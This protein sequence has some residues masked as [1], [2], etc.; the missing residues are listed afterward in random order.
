MRKRRWAAA[1]LVVLMLA[2]ASTRTA[3]AAP[4]EDNAPIANPDL[5]PGCG[6]DIHVILDE[7]TSIQQ[8]GATDD[9][10]RAFRAFTSALRNTGSRMAVSEF[11]T[12][13]R[14]PLSGAA[15]GAYT[16]VTDATIA[17]T[18]DPY[19]TIGF[20]PNGST[21]WEDAFRIG[22]YF[23]PRPSEVTPHLVVFITDG[24]PNKIVRSDQVTYD[25]GNPN[26]A[27]NEYELKVPLAEN[28]TVGA[29]ENPAKDRAV[30]N[31]NA[32]KAQGSHILTVAVGRALSSPA[33]L[34]RIIA[35]SGPDVFAG[36][37]AF[38][39]TTDDVYRVADFS[40]LEDA[41]RDAAFRLCAPS[42]NV[43]KLIDAN[44]DPT[45]DDL[46]PGQG[47]SMTANVAPAPA[48]WV[49]PQGATGATATGTTG[50]DGFVNF[51]WTTAAP[52]SSTIAVTEEVQPGFTNDQSATTCTY[53]TPDSPQ[54]RPLPG[55]SATAGGFSGIVPEDAIVTC[56]MV[57]RIPAAPAIEIEKSTNGDDADAAPGPFV[58]IGTTVTWTYRVTNT[59]NVPLSDI[60]VTDDRGV[61]VDCPGTSLD[62]A[63]VMTCRATGTAQPGQYENTGA[64][65][66]VGASQ[67]VGDSDPSHYFGVAPG[68][69]I[70]K[71]TNGDD[72]DEAPGPFIPVGGG[73]T[74]TY[75]VTNSGNAALTGVTVTDDQGVTVSCPQP[76]LAASASMTCTAP[77]ATAVAGQYENTGSVTGTA[78]DG[79]LVQDSDASHY[80]GAA[81][82]VVI[83]KSTNQFP[84]DTP[85]GPQ[86][87]VGG[88]VTWQYRVTNNGNVPLVDW[89]PTD[90]RGEAVACPRLV[91]LFPGRSV[92]CIA[93]GTAQA[94]QYTNIA[95]VTAHSAVD[96]SAPPV[97]A[98]DPSHYFGVQGAIDLEKATN[99]LDADAPPGPFVAIGGLVTRTYQ[100]TN[101]GNSTQTDVA[102]T[103]LRGVALSCPQTT[104]AVGES[105][106]CTGTGVAQAGQYTNFA[107]AEARTPLN[108]PV[109][110]GDPSN[111]FGAQP[112]IHL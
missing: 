74:W 44:P 101:T 4:G 87:A 36:D 104:L 29:N 56:Q 19:I 35:V 91:L 89:Q 15:N 31:A 46:Q 8:A 105:M 9:V 83:E 60:A 2:G 73:V 71:F 24:D 67:Q 5:P 58:P 13:A 94:G 64:V 62:V 90:S 107:I 26:V 10:R 82:S 103:D 41:L 30:P 34:A 80:F 22:R 32:V 47:W 42:V 66:A 75:E 98:T 27:Q 11:S 99:G 97:T 68:I 86:I 72:A 110:D 12:V 111:F 6:I 106:I 16:T 78:A 53:R 25:P 69:D 40:H 81:P 57:N 7:S 49:L 70:E 77:V 48:A 3:V 108:E 85:P 43:R 55:F 59:G 100:V 51:Q 76:T 17:S 45:V 93:S 92:T 63:D 88:P 84:A 54:D 39:I 1:A 112:G 14:L 65:T 37:G 28:E 52:T 109:A 96:P 102:V 50:P 18:F 23:L 79:T 38:D 95:T 33:A 61:T 21:N 20:N